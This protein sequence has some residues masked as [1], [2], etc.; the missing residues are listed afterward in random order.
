MYFYLKLKI[1]EIATNGGKMNQIKRSAVVLFNLGGPDSLNSVQAFLFNLFNDKAILNIFQPFRLLLAKFIAAKRTKKANAIYRQMGGKSPLL[2]N[3]LAQAK[4]LEKILGNE[5]KVFV[6]MRYWHPFTEETIKTVKEYA[7][8]EVILLPLY[9]QFSTTTT[10]SSFNEWYRVSRKIGLNVATRE[11]RDFPINPQFIKAHVDLLK[12][13]YQQAL[14]YGTPRILFSAH[15]LPQK[16][17][18]KGDPYQQQIEQTAVAIIDELKASLKLEDISYQV[19]YQ[20]RVGPL[21]WLEPTLEQELIKAAKDKI[22]VV[23]VPI[24]FVSEHSETLVELDIDYRTRALEL[25]IPYYGRVPTL[26]CHPLFIEAMREM[27]I[28]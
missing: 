27:V 7:P 22:P 4:A 10:Q 19:C 16:V 24:S 12:P 21:K 13:F 3:T 9:P 2:E 28:G 26:S 6:A 1:E 20:S 11:I 5:Y 14:S 23:I 18:N 25:G 15:S 8:D 17:I